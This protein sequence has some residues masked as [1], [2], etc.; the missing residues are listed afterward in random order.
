MF[1]GSKILDIV[2]VLAFS[3]MPFGSLGNMQGSREGCG[4]CKH[5][6]GWLE[7]SSVLGSLM[8][9]RGESCQRPHWLSVECGQRFLFLRQ[10]HHYRLLISQ[11]LLTPAVC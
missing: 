2:L 3:V 8:S 11:H 5:L 1:L 10:N 7:A 6:G 9:L 4:A